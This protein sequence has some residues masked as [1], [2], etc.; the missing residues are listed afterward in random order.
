MIS[1]RPKKYQKHTK[2]I[3]FLEWNS[4]SGK[5]IIEFNEHYKIIKYSRTSSDS[6][7]SDDSPDE[8]SDAFSIPFNPDSKTQ[9]A[10][11]PFPIPIITLNA[12]NGNNENNNVNEFLT[13]TSDANI[14]ESD[15]SSL[16]NCNFNQNT[17]K[18]AYIELPRGYNYIYR[19][20]NIPEDL[21]DG[22]IL[23]GELC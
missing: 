18:K 7:I 12:A 23:A 19:H 22:G 9:N 16:T 21:L 5:E 4:P 10:I 6:N 2:R 1:N 17:N 14:S 15:S 8:L 20:E 3:A 13:L 11:Q